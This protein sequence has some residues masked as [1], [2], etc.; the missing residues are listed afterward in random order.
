MNQ[1]HSLSFS[2]HLWEGETLPY[3]SAAQNRG[4]FLPSAPSWKAFLSRGAG[5]QHFSFRPKLPAAKAK[6]QGKFFERWSFLLPSSPQLWDVGCP[7]STVCWEDFPSSWGCG[8]TDCCPCPT[9]YLSPRVQM[10]L[11]QKLAIIPTPSSRALFQ[12]LCQREKQAIKRAPNLFPKKLMSFERKHDK[13][14]NWGYSQEQWRL[15][16]ETFVGNSKCRLNC[17]PSS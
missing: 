9:K 14:Q 2:F 1:D 11:K 10:L 17:K 4:L 12:R 16:W 6:S 8:S 3:T 5:G 15:W 13:V 7:L